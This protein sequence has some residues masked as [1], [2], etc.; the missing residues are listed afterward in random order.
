MGGLTLQA[1]PYCRCHG[2]PHSPNGVRR[3]ALLA[4]LL[5]AYA[6]T[7][8]ASLEPLPHFHNQAADCAKGHSFRG[9]AVLSHWSGGCERACL[10]VHFSFAAVEWELRE[11]HWA[12]A[13][14]AA[15][16]DPEATSNTWQMPRPIVWCRCTIEVQWCDL[17]HSGGHELQYTSA[18]R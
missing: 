15:K 11:N 2:T 8:A 16:G 17:V 1:P 13:L 9:W 10:F 18:E 14:D 12:F 6:P 5:V 4:G 3:S 7:V